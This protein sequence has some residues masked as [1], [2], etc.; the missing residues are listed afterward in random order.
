MGRRSEAN[1]RA[2][3]KMATALMEL[4]LQ[5]P[6]DKISITE[7][8]NAAGVSRMVYYRNYAGKKDILSRYMED[9][10]AKV[11]EDV[12]AAAAAGN[13]VVYF[14]SLFEQLSVYS[15]LGLA[16]YRADLG[17]MI[18]ENVE[19][20]VLLT[21]PAKTDSPEEIYKR[22]FVAGAFYNVFIRWSLGGKKEDPGEMAEMLS[23]FVQNVL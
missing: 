19:K 11:H 15:D 1:E 13:Y 8:T 7:I 3:K 23:R 17:D 22:R 4:M 14:K 10:G 21:F 5:K 18:L 12:A 2:R 9:V 6:Y 16:L 20:N